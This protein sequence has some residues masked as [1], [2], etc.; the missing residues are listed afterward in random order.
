LSSLPQLVAP[1]YRFSGAELRRRRKAAGLTTEQL[2]TMIGRSYRI[3]NLYESGR[4]FPSADVIARAASALNVDPAVFF[5]TVDT[6][7]P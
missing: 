4:G 3:T 5:V 6:D 1:R 2:S 7:Q